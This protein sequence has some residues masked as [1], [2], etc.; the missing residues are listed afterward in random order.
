[1]EH[2][3]THYTKEQIGEI[4]Q[5]ESEPDSYKGYGPAW[6][7]TTQDAKI[8][9][10]PK[11]Y[12]KSKI[13]QST[14]RFFTDGEWKWVLLFP[15]AVPVLLGIMIYDTYQKWDRNRPE[16]RQQDA[17]YEQA[18]QVKRREYFSNYFAAE[19]EELN[20]EWTPIELPEEIDLSFNTLYPASKPRQWSYVGADLDNPPLPPD[21]LASL[22]CG[23]CGK[24]K[25]WIKG[26]SEE[27]P[28]PRCK[29]TALVKYKPN[30]FE[31][32]DPNVIYD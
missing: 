32:Y 3:L 26:I 21:P 24:Q 1:M 12:G 25:T 4:L 20:Q 14:I 30:T 28:C 22:V 27:K 29:S 8:N 18:F 19:I 10:I 17:L 7:G 9:L 16:T 6:Q 31:I 5:K 11:S 13:E 2:Y 15:L 23:C